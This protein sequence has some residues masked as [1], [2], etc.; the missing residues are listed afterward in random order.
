MG[1]AA[2]ILR[3]AFDHSSGE[4]SR[5]CGRWTPN[6]GAGV[7]EG[8]RQMLKETNTR[9]IREIVVSATEEALNAAIAER[10]IA[11]DK[12]ISVIYEP[13]KELAIGDYGAKYRVIYR[14]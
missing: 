10:G 1:C 14:S 3:Q 7:D 11:P 4:R 12:I 13:R 2:A 5:E 6:Q 8:R 9:D